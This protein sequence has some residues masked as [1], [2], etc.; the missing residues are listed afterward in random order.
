MQE[1]V[2]A[3]QVIETR[4]ASEKDQLPDHSKGRE[5]P[6]PGSATLSW[7]RPRDLDSD[8]GPED[9]RSRRG[10]PWTDQSVPDSGDSTAKGPAEGAGLER[11]SNW[12]EP[13][14]PSRVREAE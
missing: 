1:Q 13:A 9:G 6:R 8:S 12:A 4:Q 14:W 3:G 2:P 5:E 11:A 10:W 7:F